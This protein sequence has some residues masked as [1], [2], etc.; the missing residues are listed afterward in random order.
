[1]KVAHGGV[2]V[3]CLKSEELLCMRVPLATG[4]RFYFQFK[5]IF[6]SF[7]LGFKM[8]PKLPQSKTLNGHVKALHLIFGLGGHWPVKK[9][10]TIVKDV[11]SSDLAPD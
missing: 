8:K 4:S 3:T 2:D 10:F 1:M 6:S 11:K 7:V 9:R 5:N